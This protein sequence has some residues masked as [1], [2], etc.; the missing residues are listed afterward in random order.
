MPVWLLE[1]YG[2]DRRY[3]DVRYRVYTTSEKRADEFRQ[4]PRIQFSDSGHGIVFAA[5]KLPHGTRRREVRRGL[6]EYV[7]EQLAIIRK[8]KAGK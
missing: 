1:G 8:K 6:E 5:T 3:D 2:T 7:N 4:I